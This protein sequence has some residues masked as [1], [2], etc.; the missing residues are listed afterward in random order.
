[1]F[2]ALR[3]RFFSSDIY[4]HLMVDKKYF[5]NKLRKEVIST[6]DY[7]LFFDGAAKGNPGPVPPFTN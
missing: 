7:F 3:Y 4:Q 6:S 2:R 5:P 1:M